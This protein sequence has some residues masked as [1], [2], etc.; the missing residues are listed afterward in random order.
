ML[1]TGQV[2]SSH[3]SVPN[4]KIKQIGKTIYYYKPPYYPKNN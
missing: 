1:N 3:V 4:N 2:Y